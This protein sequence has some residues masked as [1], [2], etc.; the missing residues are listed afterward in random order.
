[1]TER[2]ALL[3][4][5]DTSSRVFDGAALDA[6]S[7]FLASYEME[8]TLNASPEMLQALDGAMRTLDGQT[9]MVDNQLHTAIELCKLA[10][11]KPQRYTAAADGSWTAK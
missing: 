8:Q 3:G 7:A 6:V 5:M 9:Y 10:T 11:A 4:L 2:L 1:M